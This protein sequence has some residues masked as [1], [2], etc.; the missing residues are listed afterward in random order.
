MCGSVVQ[1]AI[2]RGVTRRGAKPRARGSGDV[3]YVGVEMVGLT[4]DEAEAG[5]RGRVV[6]QSV[7]VR[8]ACDD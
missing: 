4:D 8:A 6:T 3:W 1:G 7:G 2:G 5:S